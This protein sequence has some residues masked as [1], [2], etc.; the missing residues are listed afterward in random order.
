MTKEIGKERKKKT[1]VGTLVN[2]MGYGI[3]GS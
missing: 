1:L 3:R 2:G